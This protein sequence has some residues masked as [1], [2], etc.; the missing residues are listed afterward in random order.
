MARILITGG[1]GFLGTATVNKALERGH[2]VIVFDRH[3]EVKKWASNNWFNNTDIQL[4]MGDLKDRDAVFE[5]VNHCDSVINLGG[6]LGTSEMVNNPIPAVEVNIL[7]ALHIFDAMRTYSK[8]G[9]QIAVGNYWMNNP[10]S[11]TKNTTERFALMYNKEHGTSIVVVRGL[12]VYG[13]GQKASPVRKI[14]PN[15]IIPA[16]KNEEIIIYGDGSQ[17][18]DFIYI[19][20]MAT[21]LIYAIEKEIDC[22][23]IYEAGMGDDTTINHLVNEIIDITQSK[24]KVSHIPMRPGEEPNSVVKANP[25]TLKPLG[26]DY[27]KFIT[28]RYGLERSVKWYKE[29][30]SEF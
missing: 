18:M 19:D 23:V 15:V 1:Q 20:D 21:I 14:V 11:I 30:L 4:R 22:S 2:K 16:L 24:S 28:L 25:K 5:A 29:H 3:L 17:I 7:G 6:L 8:K 27:K 26:I 9:V 12:N 13:P 10:Y